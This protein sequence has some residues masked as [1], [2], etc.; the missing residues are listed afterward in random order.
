MRSVS[1]PTRV[2]NWRSRCP[3]RQPVRAAVRSCGPA[4]RNVANSS[5]IMDCSRVA[6]IERRASSGARAGSCWGTTAD[7]LFRGEVIVG[8][9]GP[10]GGNPQW[11]V[12]SPEDVR[13]PSRFNPTASRPPP[14]YTTLCTRPT[15]ARYLVH[16]NVLAAQQPLEV[17]IMD[18]LLAGNSATQYP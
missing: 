3:L 18:G 15:L 14:N 5:S 12:D 8:L 1:V 2:V 7:V 16:L 6:S 4:P 17:H 11:M 10:A 9:L 13:W